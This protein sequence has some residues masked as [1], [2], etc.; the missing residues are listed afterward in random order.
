MRSLIRISL[1]L[2]LCACLSPLLSSA[3]NCRSSQAHFIEDHSLVSSFFETGRKVSFE[4]NDDATSPSGPWYQSLPVR[5]SS[6]IILIITALVILG[7]HFRFRKN[8]KQKLMRAISM[9]TVRLQ[10]ANELLE[11]QKKEI[12]DKSEQLEAQNQTISELSSLK[13]RYF[14]NISHE[15]RTLI[16]LIKSPIEKL[17]S[18]S[19]IPRKNLKDLELIRR[20]AGRLIELVNQLLDL[21]RLDRGKMTIQLI[22]ANVFDFVHTIAVSF[23]SFAEV[24]GISY[25]YD[26]PSLDQQ[27]WIDHDK[28]EKILNNLLSN[29]FKF[30]EEG[31][32]IHFCAG[33]KNANNGAPAY[34]EITVSDTGPGISEE[35]QLKIFDRFY[36]AENSLSKGYGGTGLGLA[37]SYDLAMLLKGSL[38]VRSE[39]GYGSTFVLKVPLGKEHLQAHEFTL[40]KEEA[41]LSEQEIVDEGHIL[42][43]NGFKQDEREYPL[44]EHTGHSLILIVEDHNEIRGMIKDYLSKEY[45][46]LEAVDGSA[47]LHLA[48]EHLPDLVVTDLVMPRLDG[49]ELCYKLKT[50]MLTSHIPVIM[51]TAKSSIE[52]RLRGYQTGADDY[53]LKPFNV[54]ELA[55]RIKG[56]IDLRK[57]LRLKFSEHITVGP[58]DIPI[59]SLDKKFLENAIKVVEKHM[60]DENFNVTLMSSEMNMSRSTL[61]RKLEAL[62]GQSPVE[63]IRSIRLKRAASL[64]MQH[65][66]N[67]SEIALQVGFKN[68][69]YFTNLFR[70]AYAKTP[71]EYASSL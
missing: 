26:I 52:F 33:R 68:P 4:G 25:R 34:L 14:A 49:M 30:T 39:L 17:I 1:M 7:L 36:Q 20:N 37:L 35:E 22:E 24:K 16:T 64:L 47:G 60:S 42:S 8:L 55:V 62:T 41:A 53:I 40:V 50:D 69:S 61:F 19:R 23:T 2:A 27:D 46:I 63:F 71:R 45:Q 65:Y 67:I 66:G 3:S 6:Y 18:E 10:R 28:I 21:S 48:R 38:E 56:L 12:Q 51:L 44:N 31:G 11:Q 5:I 29:A 54:E 58:T 43:L 32:Q 70:K 57:S 13:T 9:E 15:F 59:T